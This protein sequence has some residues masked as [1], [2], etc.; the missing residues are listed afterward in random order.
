MH[1]TLNHEEGEALGIEWEAKIKEGVSASPPGPTPHPHPRPTH[2]VHKLSLHL[3][4]DALIHE[5]QKH[6]NL[7][8]LHLNLGSATHLSDD[9]G[10]LS[11]LIIKKRDNHTHFTFYLLVCLFICLFVYLFIY[12]YFWLHWVFVAARGLS[13]VAASGG[14]SS[15]WCAGFSLWWLL[16]LRSTGSRH[17]SFSSCGTQAQ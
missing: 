14:Y 7:G 6:I 2:L 10:H 5:A 3:N 9:L 8:D 16:L 12:L 17:T 1:L 13:L 15:L 11:F 4:P